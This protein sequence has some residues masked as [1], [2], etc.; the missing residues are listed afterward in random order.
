MADALFPRSNDLRGLVQLRSGPF[1]FPTRMFNVD[2]LV[3]TFGSAGKSES[4]GDFQDGAAW[5]DLC[6]LCVDIW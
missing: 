5:P 1:I 6:T 2:D 3:F 4:F